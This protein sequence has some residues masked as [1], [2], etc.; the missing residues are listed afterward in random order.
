MNGNEGSEDDGTRNVILVVTAQDDTEEKEAKSQDFMNTH[1]NQNE[2]DDP[3]QNQFL[4]DVDQADGR[5]QDS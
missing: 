1:G 4:E 3:I 5:N 2:L